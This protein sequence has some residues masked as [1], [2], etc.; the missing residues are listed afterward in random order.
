MQIWI[1]Y[2]RISEDSPDKNRLIDT[3][4]QGRSFTALPLKIY[5]A[6]WEMGRISRR[7]TYR[8]KKMHMVTEA[9]SARGKAHQIGRAHV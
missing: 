8:W 9:S 1:T 4:R 5:S 3:K 7:Y 2:L 6:F